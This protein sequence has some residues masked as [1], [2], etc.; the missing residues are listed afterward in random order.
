MSFGPYCRLESPGQRSE[1][2]LQQVGAGEIRG[3]A[4][5]AN[6]SHACIKAYPRRLHGSERGITFST[7]VGHDRRFSAPH[8]ARWYYP[9]TPGVKQRT[10]AQG[11]P[12][13][14]VAASV[15]NQQP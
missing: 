3:R 13:A 5:P 7:L 6:M 8:E 11:I 9:L 10:D 1:D 12:L 2:A 4:H 15:T 14:A